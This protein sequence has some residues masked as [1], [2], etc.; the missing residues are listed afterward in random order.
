MRLNAFI[1]VESVKIDTYIWRVSLQNAHMHT[2]NI[3]KTQT[4]NMIDGIKL[5]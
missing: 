2:S 3:L 4:A 5:L 1:N